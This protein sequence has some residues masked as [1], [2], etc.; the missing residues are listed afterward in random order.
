M[1]TPAPT[2]PVAPWAATVAGVQD[3]LPDAR[4]Y[5][6]AASVPAGRRGV[7]APQVRTWLVALSGRASLYLDGWERLS[8][9]VDP[10]AELS[11]RARFVDLARDAVHNGAASYVESA[12]YPEQQGK[13]AS[14]YAGVLW[15]R[16][17]AT[18]RDLREWL[19]ARLAATGTDPQT[20]A[21]TSAGPEFAFPP[22]SFTVDRLRF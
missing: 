8:D 7:T 6:D 12:R 9:E 17:E 4:I 18:L 15:S 5:P 2:D 16:Y 19:A 11:D 22:P 10:G 14:T 1:T 20:G 21:A 3:L 13:A